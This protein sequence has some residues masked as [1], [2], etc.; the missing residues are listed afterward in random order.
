MEDKLKEGYKMP[1]TSSS[2]DELLQ[3]SI[4]WE[5]E[6]GTYHS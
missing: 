3:I 2:K 5:K 6:S 1:T 4:D